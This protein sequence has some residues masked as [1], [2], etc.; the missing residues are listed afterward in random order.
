MHHKPIISGVFLPKMCNLN[1]ITRK[2]LQTDIE[3]YSTKQ[4]SWNLISQGHE[5][6]E[7][8][9]ERFQIEGY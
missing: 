7:K 8:D 6:Q 9:E 3:G 5:C 2:Y 1:V 4:L